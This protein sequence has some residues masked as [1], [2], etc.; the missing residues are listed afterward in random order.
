M[1][2]ENYTVRFIYQGATAETVGN[3]AH[4]NDTITR[5]NAGVAILAAAADVTASHVGTYVHSCEDHSSSATLKCHDPNS[6]LYNVTISRNG[7]TVQSYSDDAILAKVDTW[8]DD[9]PALA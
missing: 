9:V 2:R 8:N 1:T 6:E 7:V 4:S 5:Y 3:G